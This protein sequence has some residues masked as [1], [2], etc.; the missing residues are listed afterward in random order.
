MAL[1]EN[2]DL[3]VNKK[4]RVPVCLL[5]DIS[6]SMFQEEH[7]QTC[8]PRIET[9]VEGVSLFMDAIETDEVALDRADVSIVTFDRFQPKVIQDFANVEDIDR[10]FDIE[11]GDGTFI[12]EAINFTLDLL[13]NRKI[14]YKKAGISYY[15]PW[16]VVFTDGEG[17][18]DS[19][20]FTKARKR[21]FQKIPDNGKKDLLFIPVNFGSD[22]GYETLST[23]IPPAN[24][25]KKPLSYNI[26]YR[27]FFKWL[28]MSISEV[29]SSDTDVDYNPFS[30]ANPLKGADDE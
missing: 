13:E 2:D 1:I 17:N 28:A 23:L 24:S 11:E 18:G 9:L 16:L 19:G 20:E 3:A 8:K 14:D 22:E 4:P 10:S 29:T 27:E 25:P 30:G 7:P 5:L 12:G 26:D 6:P 21:I 15:Q